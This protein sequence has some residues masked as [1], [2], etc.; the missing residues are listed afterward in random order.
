MY[1]TR[2]RI[3]FDLVRENGTVSIQRLV[4]RLGVSDMTVRRDIG[5]MAA[6]GLLRRV[7]GGAAALES[8]P[9]DPPFAARQVEELARKQAIARFAAQTLKG[10]ESLYLDGSTTCG[11][12]ARLIPAEL[13]FLVATDSLHVVATLSRHPKVELLVLGGVLQHDGNTI[14]GVLAVESARKVMVDCCFFSAKGFTSEYISNAVMIGSQVKQIMIR[15]SSRTVFLADSTKL[16][17][18]GVIKLCD[19]SEVDEFLTDDGL[20]GAEIE[21][22]RSKDTQ[23]HVVPSEE[24]TL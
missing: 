19:W 20:P 24:C 15:S 3:I 22:I 9:E 17:A 11:E 13:P 12:L 6:E 16:G 1:E 14:D 7:H 21:A 8:P 4:D 18:R 10:G 5:A 23:V 2:K